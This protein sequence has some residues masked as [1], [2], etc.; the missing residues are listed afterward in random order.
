M[1]VRQLIRG[2]HHR[3]RVHTPV[4]ESLDRF[5]RPNH[6]GDAWRK[7]TR[8]CHSAPGRLRWNIH[9]NADGRVG[10]YDRQGR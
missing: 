4:L 7:R 5:G 3:N 9:I 1:D 10:V 6:R 2:S 8:A